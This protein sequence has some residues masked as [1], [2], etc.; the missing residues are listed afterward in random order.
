MRNFRSKYRFQQWHLLI[1]VPVVYML[2]KMLK[3]GKVLGMQIAGSINS[4]AQIAGVKAALLQSG[5]EGVREAAV[6]DAAEGI[7]TAFYK[8]SFWG[9]GE[10]EEKAVESINMLL[11]AAEAKAAAHIYKANYKKSLYSD[12]MKFVGPLDGNHKNIKQFILLATK[13]I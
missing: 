10:D 8:D 5:I 13:G 2:Y 3:G 4:S 12:F 9:A 6:Q 1:I 11:S 7:Y